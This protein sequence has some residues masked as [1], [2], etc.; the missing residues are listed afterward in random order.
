MLRFISR[1][2]VMGAGSALLMIAAASADCIDPYKPA[3]ERTE[4]S[5][6]LNSYAE[7]SEICITEKAE[8]CDHCVA[9]YKH[10]CEGGWWQPQMHLSCSANAAENDQAAAIQTPSPDT[11]TTDYS[12]LKAD[13]SKGPFIIATAQPVYPIR[14][15]SRGV[16]GQVLVEYRVSAQGLPYNVQVV[17]TASDLLNEAAISAMQQ[18]RFDPAL[19]RHGRPIDSHKLEYTFTFELQ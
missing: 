13:R 18:F 11:R 6:N 5:T 14:A 4:L 1:T 19:D 17:R 15:I 12:A 2:I 10:K 9:G 16:H 7:E 8:F 3:I